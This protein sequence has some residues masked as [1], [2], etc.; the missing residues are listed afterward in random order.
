MSGSIR[1]PGALASAGLLFAS[2]SG[3]GLSGALA[4]DQTNPSVDPASALRFVAEPVVQALPL[5]TAE[6]AQPAPDAASLPALVSGMP[7]DA[8]L[9]R[10][11]NC[12]AQAVYFEAR[13]EPLDGQLAVAQVII[14]R[15]ESGRFPAD[16]CGVVAQRGQ[17]SFVRGGHIPTA[18]AASPAWHRARAI[19][20][21]AH[22]DLWDSRVGESLYF[23]ATHVRPAWIRGRAQVARIDS[24][25]FYE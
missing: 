21:I 10:E 25:V 18:P 22:Q 24:H 23:H 9:S 8:A 6:P 2:L 19:A 12:L 11:L 14:N 7:A 1:R 13:G 17:F 4:Q 3:V 20:Q 5:I 16:Y 15:A